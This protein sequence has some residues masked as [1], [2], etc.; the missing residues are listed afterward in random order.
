MQ[1]I[2]TGYIFRHR[3]NHYH[4]KSQRSNQYVM[5]QELVFAV[6]VWELIAK[7]GAKCILNSSVNI[8]NMPCNVLNLISSQSQSSWKKDLKLRRRYTQ[9]RYP[10]RRH[11]LSAQRRSPPLPPALLT[12]L[13]GSPPSKPEGG[14]LDCGVASAYGEGSPSF[15][16]KG[17]EPFP[18]EMSVQRRAS[19]RSTSKLVRAWHLGQGLGSKQILQ[20]LL[21]RGKPSLFIAN[22]SS[23]LQTYSTQHTLSGSVRARQNGFRLSREPHK[24][25]VYVTT[26]IWQ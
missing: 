11:F 23:P 17:T 22:I 26:V 10:F 1:L 7:Y 9:L 21:K 20:V 15:L 5:K 14:V 12:A 6:Y 18:W 8:R 19:F 24:V 2:I 25:N 13:A 4:R 3:R 16:H